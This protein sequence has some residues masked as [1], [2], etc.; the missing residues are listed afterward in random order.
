MAYNEA[1]RDIERLKV[2]L[3]GGV[4]EY[5]KGINGKRI[6]YPAL[7]GKANFKHVEEYVSFLEAKGRNS[8]TVVKNLYCLIKFFEA[9]K[10]LGLERLDLARAK[11]GDLQRIVAALEK[12]KMAAATKM[13]IKIVLKSLYKHILGEDEFFPEPIRWIKTSRNRSRN[14]MP[15]DILTEEDIMKLINGTN[16]LR[17][18]AIVALLFDSGIRAGELMALRL[19]D[20]SLDTQPA[21]IR[22]DGKTGQR[23]IPIWFSVPYL[24]QY[25]NTQKRLR[26]EDHIW[27]EAY[28]PDSDK[29]GKE[30]DYSGV[31][32]ML[33]LLKKK[34]GINKRCNPHTFRHSR[35]T[36]Y[37]NKLT[38]QQLKV[39]FG[40]T[41]DSRMAATYVHLSGR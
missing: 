21:H 5:K 15:E 24:V 14:I 40:W 20:I 37:A 36:F 4:W 1:E 3:R 25:L 18:K 32:N 2:Q 39:F 19:K 31:R 28:L 6:E 26:D 38:E 16:N 34:T 13:D 35:A 9:M 17:D 23:K 29:L 8:R 27:R 10:Q 12:S 30:I 7:I 33:S 11:R 41:G 22:V